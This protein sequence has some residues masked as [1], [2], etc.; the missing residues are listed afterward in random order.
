MSTSTQQGIKKNSNF[1]IPDLNK[2][3][4]NKTL[5]AEYPKLKWF[6]GSRSR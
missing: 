3:L 4:I 5:T 6:K 1:L 2:Y